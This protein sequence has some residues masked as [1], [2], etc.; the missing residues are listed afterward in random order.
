MSKFILITV[1]QNN[2]VRTISHTLPGAGGKVWVI[3]VIAVLFPRFGC[4]WCFLFNGL[5]IW[6]CWMWNATWENREWNGKKETSYFIKIPYSPSV[7]I[8]P[9]NKNTLIGGVKDTNNENHFVGISIENHW[10]VVRT[11]TSYTN[12]HVPRLCWGHPLRDKPDRFPFSK[13]QVWEFP[14]GRPHQLPARREGEMLLPVREQEAL[15]MTPVGTPAG[16]PPRERAHSVPP[17]VPKAHAQ[18]LRLRLRLPAHGHLLLFLHLKL[19]V[20]VG[21]P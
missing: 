5:H 14:C 18:P 6:G 9:L 7:F 16:T 2:T 4:D 12:S 1:F 19:K 10:T 8:Y 3:A 17:A 11:G 13:N 21:Q 20:L 15:R